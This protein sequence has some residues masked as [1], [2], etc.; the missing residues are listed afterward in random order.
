MDDAHKLAHPH[1]GLLHLCARWV[2]PIGQACLTWL[3][4]IYCCL[5]AAVL[6]TVCVHCAVYKTA[7]KSLCCNDWL[8][9]ALE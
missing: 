7:N 2:G 5:P 8:S 1:F 4:H 9:E 3:H 6:C